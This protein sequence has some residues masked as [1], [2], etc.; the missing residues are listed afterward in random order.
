MIS[1]T[2]E[3]LSAV[4]S[5]L[6]V[7]VFRAALTCALPVSATVLFFFIWG[8]IDGSVSSF[9][10][11]LWFAL[12]AVVAGVPIIGWCLRASGKL[13][14]AILVLSVLV[15]PGLFYLLFLILVVA[16]GSSWR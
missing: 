15:V 14:T 4:A 7:W 5:T 10:G 6:A 13:R 2:S 12:L 8:L 16:S 9:N 11:T 3:S 1:S